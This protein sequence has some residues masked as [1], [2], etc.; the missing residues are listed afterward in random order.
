MSGSRTSSSD[1]SSSLGVSG[2]RPQT[3]CSDACSPAEVSRG[4]G[5]YAVHSAPTLWPLLSRQKILLTW[6]PFLPHPSHAHWGDWSEKV[7]SVYYGHAGPRCNW[8]RKACRSGRVIEGGN[9]DA[10]S[11]PPPPKV[12]C[13][14]NAWQSRRVGYK[15]WSTGSGIGA[16]ELVLLKMVQHLI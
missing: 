8:C 6:R 11:Y 13:S 7:S 1:I 5:V 4:E 16:H 15:T 9:D 3:S 2:R 14:R 12:W 10:C